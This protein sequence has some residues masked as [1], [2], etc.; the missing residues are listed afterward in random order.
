MEPEAA[1]TVLAFDNPWQIAALIAATVTLRLLSAYTGFFN[2]HDTLR[3]WRAGIL[4]FIDSLLIALLLVFC[5]LR[6]FVIQAF[7][8]PS[9]SMLPTLQ[10]NDRILVNKFI[11]HFSGP[12]P[13]DIV[14]F[15]APPAAD[16]L[17]RD[18]IKRV[19]GTPGDR[20]SIHDGYLF[21]NGDKIVEP[22][23]AEQPMYRWPRD[24]TG[25]PDSITVPEGNL[26]VLGDNRNVSNDSKSWGAVSSPGQIEHRPFLPMENVKGEAVFIFYPFGRIRLLR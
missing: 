6:P 9:G 21:R 1:G 16:H 3:N 18:F 4:E 8:I 23:V 25:Q 10:I 11:Y 12:E 20:I 13:G 24:A 26:I 19:V 5:V 14:V 17:D 22:Y 15:Q 7:F 2:L